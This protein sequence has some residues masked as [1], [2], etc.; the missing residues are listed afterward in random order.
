MSSA[1]TAATISERLNRESGRPC[2][3]GNSQAIALTWATCS[4]GKDR[5]ASRP[6]LI[7]QGERFLAP[8][9]PPFPHRLLGEAELVGSCD[10]VQAGFAMKQEGQAGALNLDIRSLATPNEFPAHLQGIRR[11]IRPIS[12]W[13][14]CHD[15]TP[16]AGCRDFCCG[17]CMVIKAQEL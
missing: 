17:S 15:A 8:T 10:A 3:A 9:L 16:F 5:G 2:F 13:A 4:G 7:L 12:A 6:R 1:N 11:E 14:S